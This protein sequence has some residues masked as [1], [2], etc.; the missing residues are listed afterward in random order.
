MKRFVIISVLI[1]S[2]SITAI[3]QNYVYVVNGTAETLSRIDIATGAVD[4][5]MVT[6]GVVPNQVVYY[7]NMLY[8]V[9]SGMAGLQVINPA[10]NTIVQEIPLPMGSNPWHAAFYG[11]F[12]YVTGFAGSSVFKVDLSNGSVVATYTVGP[13]PAGLIELNGR[14]YV[15]NTAFNPDDY[16]YGQG[17]VSI[18]DL[19]NG[20]ALA[21]ID[22]GKNPQAMAVGPDGVISVVCTGDYYSITGRVYFLAPLNNSIIDSISTGGNPYL[23]VINPSGIGFLSAGGWDNDGYVFSYDA[24]SHRVLRGS[25]NPIRVGRG[26]MGIALDSLGML[27]S[28]GQMADRITQFDSQGTTYNTYS[29]GDGPVSLAIIDSRTSIDDFGNFVPINVSLDLPYPNPFNSNVILSL[30]G[31]FSD[32]KENIIEIF[33]CT[34]RLINKLNLGSNHSINNY[35]IWSGIDYEGRDVASG[36][37]FAH[38]RGTTRAVKMVL[39]R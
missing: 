31:D 3:A 20:S 32:C 13:S 35:I 7:R 34:G 30:K 18:I 8:V 33:D 10:N 38:L 9:N 17:S 2:L 39:L 4:N 26:S 1:F 11:E 37:Y 29:V 6:L 5:H 15:A 28:A 21:Q 25:A 23:P 19:N 24:I 27:Y 14:L 12:A 22:V 36:V 16:S